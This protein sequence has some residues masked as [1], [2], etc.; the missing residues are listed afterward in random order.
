VEKNGRQE[1][2]EG[3]EREEEKMI[4]EEEELIASN[5][6]HTD[7]YYSAHKLMISKDN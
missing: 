7:M 2:E 4:S 6:S 5:K 1:E 3:S